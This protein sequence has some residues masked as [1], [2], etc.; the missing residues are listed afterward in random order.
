MQTYTYDFLYRF[1]ARR[2]REE[3]EKM[4]SQEM[5]SAQQQHSKQQQDHPIVP[6]QNVGS[7][8]HHSAVQNDLKLGLGMGVGGV[9]NNLGMMGNLDKSNQDILKAVSKIN[10]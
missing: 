5:K 8:L 6:S 1:Q 7:H 2:D 4:K 10:T 9:G 3:Q